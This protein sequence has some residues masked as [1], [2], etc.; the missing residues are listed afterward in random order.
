MPEDLGLQG[1]TELHAVLS[2]IVPGGWGYFIKYAHITR[3]DVTVDLPGVR[4]GGFLMM[5]FQALTSMQFWT[6]GKLT[7]VT[8]GKP[9]GDQTLIYNRK[10][11]R[12]SKKQAWGGASET[13]VERRL[14][15]SGDKKL[16]YLWSMPNPFAK[17][18]MIENMPGPPFGEDE[19]RWQRFEDSVK[20]R[21]LN[22]ALALLP[23][24]RRTQYRKHL[25]AHPAP[26]WNAEKIWTNSPKWLDAMKIANPKAWT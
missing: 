5:P 13:R 21:G 3:L 11:K 7:S 15:I 26:W 18:Q 22:A 6:D 25:A 4:I 14:V 8:H 20:V 10:Q 16:D 2:S 17:L 9:G 23:V 19:K 24:A 12:L 1:L